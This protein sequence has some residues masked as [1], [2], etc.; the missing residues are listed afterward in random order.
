MIAIWM[1]LFF[2]VISLLA[3]LMFFPAARARIAAWF[4][5]WR[6][7]NAARL[8]RIGARAASRANDSSAVVR[9]AG[10]EM[11]RRLS[12][13]RYLLLG[14]LLL[15]CVPPLLILHFRQRVALDG[16][17]AT[18]LAESNTQIMELLRGERLVPPPALAP[19][20]FIAA[21][22]ARVEIGAAAIIPEKIVSADRRWDRIDPDLQQRVLAIYKVMHDQ[23]GYQMALVE[24]YRSPERQA[25]LARAGKAT[26]AGAG[27]SCHQYGLAVDSAPFRDGKLQW[28]MNDPWTR[29]GYFLYGRLAQ[30]A[31]LNWGGSWKSLKDYVHV[32]MARACRDARRAAGKG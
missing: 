8:S 24:G 12:R 15:V 30:E 13:H 5:R 11:G 7:R 32:E 29:R 2:A 1:A 27:Q 21:E 25:E 4:G 28:D 16:F 9:H 18:E 14:T 20:V 22:A 23:Y 26:R 10:G 19:E 6:G 31:G 17:D 3:W